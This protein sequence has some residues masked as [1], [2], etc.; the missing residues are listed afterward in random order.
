MS[1]RNLRLRGSRL[2]QFLQV[3]PGDPLRQGA[4]VGRRCSPVLPSRRAPVAASRTHLHG[5]PPLGGAELTFPT[6]SIL[7]FPSPKKRTESWISK[8]K[9]LFPIDAPAP[10]P[11]TA[12]PPTAGA[13]CGTGHGPSQ[14][15]TAP[16][17]LGSCWKL[18]G[19]SHTPED[20]GF[21]GVSEAGHTELCQPL[22][23][24]PGESWR[25][26]KRSNTALF[27]SLQSR[28]KAKQA[29]WN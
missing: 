16:G 29:A 9:K 14:F 20:I 23:A 21:V 1:L 19:S 8:E 2:L 15:L 10:L 25:N 12:R 27:L 18:P 6:L 28:T 4:G 3:S 24:G 13:R 22:P 11:S 26:P 17:P 5:E 7:P